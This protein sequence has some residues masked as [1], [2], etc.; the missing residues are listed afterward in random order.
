MSPVTGLMMRR[1]WAPCSDQEHTELPESLSGGVRSQGLALCAMC[2]LCNPA[3]TQQ[4]RVP[5]PGEELGSGHWEETSC[6]RWAS[7]RLDRGRQ[8]AWAWWP[9]GALVW[10]SL[11]P[12]PSGSPQPADPLSGAGRVGC[13]WCPASCLVPCA[14]VLLFS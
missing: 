11:L 12:K 4:M 5:G 14:H 13:T 2:G 1:V 10:D 7:C 8:Q 3:G 9:Q 6:A